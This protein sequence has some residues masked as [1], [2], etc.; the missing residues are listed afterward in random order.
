[1]LDLTFR[2]LDMR[3][4]SCLD[5]TSDLVSSHIT[6]FHRFLFNADDSRC[7]RHTALSQP[8]N[9]AGFFQILS[10]SKTLSTSSRQS[11]AHIFRAILPNPLAVHCH[12]SPPPSPPS[13]I[14][15]RKKDSFRVV[16]RFFLFFLF[17][18]ALKDL[19][20]ILPGRRL[21]FPCNEPFKYSGSFF[22]GTKRDFKV[23][24]QRRR[25]NIYIYIYITDSYK[26]F[27]IIQDL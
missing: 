12:H 20:G 19:E 3:C 17:W 10:H 23:T 13:C 8:K 22:W 21:Q 24:F 15:I 16:S 25:R 2:W 7:I 4:R 6:R 18:Q 11:D 5:S 9:P 26:S 1:M 27:K 14:I